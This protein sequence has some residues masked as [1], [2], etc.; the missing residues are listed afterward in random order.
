LQKNALPGGETNTRPR[1]PAVSPQKE[2]EDAK[3]A[4]GWCGRHQIDEMTMLKIFLSVAQPIDYQIP[5][6]MG[7]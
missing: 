5:E 4:E 3:L 2:N 1:S 7:D 6:V